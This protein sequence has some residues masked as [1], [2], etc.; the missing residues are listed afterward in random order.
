MVYFVRFASP[1]K[2]FNVVCGLCIEYD[3][4][5]W[6]VKN[7]DDDDDGDVSDYWLWRMVELGDDTYIDFCICNKYD[8]WDCDVDNIDDDD[9]D[10]D[11]DVDVY[12]YDEWW[13]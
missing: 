6:D 2:S 4:C 1:L 10:D 5:D 9:D 11:D 8:K 3:Q 7:I 13:S 12:V